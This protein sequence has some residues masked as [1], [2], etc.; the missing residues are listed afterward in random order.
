MPDEWEQQLA[1]LRETLV[2]LPPLVKRIAHIEQIKAA[3]KD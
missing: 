1:V 2:V 3:L